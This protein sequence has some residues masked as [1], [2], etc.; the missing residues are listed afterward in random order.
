MISRRC[1]PQIAVGAV[2]LTLALH[3]PPPLAAQRPV[4][5]QRGGQPRADTPQLV[6]GVLA[7]QDPT[8]G[9]AAA[10]AIRR[11]IQDQHTAT[12][13]YVV[14]KPKLDQ[15][16]LSS[17]YNPD[18]ALG[19][20]DLVALTKQVR[21]DYALSG[22][23]ERTK[24]GVRTL[25]RLFTQTGKEI[26]TEPL[27][28]MVGADFG[29]VA[30]QV[31]RAVADALRALV[32]YHECAKS[33]AVRDYT[34]ALA[35]AR[36]GLKLR[37]ESV[38]LNLCVL[39]AL[40]PT[41][42]SPDSIIAVARVVIAA[43][44]ENVI[45]WSNLPPAYDAKGDSARALDA[46]QTLHRLDPSDLKTTLDLTDRLAR[47]GR[48]SSA[49]AVIETALHDAPENAELLRKQWQLHLRLGEF[50]RA[51]VSGAALIAA[52]S[53]AAT[54]EYYDRQIRAASAAHDSVALR[55]IATDAAARFPRNTNPLQILAR[56]A[57]ERGDFRGSLSFAERML[58]V[59]PANEAAWQLTIAAHIRMNA[60]DSAFA[61]GRRALAAGVS[62]DVVGSALLAL[63]APSL[64]DAQTDSSRAKWE[65]VLGLVQVVESVAAT[66]R[67]AFY[68]G[69]SAFQVATDEIQSLA[70]MAKRQSPT[71][72]QR[73]AACTSATLL[74]GL[75]RTVTIAMPRGGK[76]DPATA[77]K[78]LGAMPN[79]SEFVASMKQRSCR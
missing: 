59:E 63:V 18:S 76:E 17:G 62:K 61:A 6:V 50:S 38:A 22:T 53:S 10:N 65:A 41:H 1:S 19:P 43:D 15:A 35:A 16:L 46:A 39:S 72:A 21:G 13:L 36:Q 69:V 42:A 31:D 66:Q 56:D 54:S 70:E 20:T 4:A 3:A 27:P 75:V 73:Q 78:I 57:I 30:K 24:S 14:P 77:A 34:Q 48:D 37:P 11:R 7:S 25:M 45:A 23:I 55:R 74:E 52:D 5:E 8:I 60:T 67:S 29:D 64:H 68:L 47:A 12:D 51:L 9:V 2:A 26:I 40:V 71:R 33:L 79:Y 58:A 44:S 49:L 28:P 32:F